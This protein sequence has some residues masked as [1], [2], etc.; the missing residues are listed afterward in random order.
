MGKA[1]CSYFKEQ[2][3]EIIILS[4]GPERTEKNLRF[5]FW[6]GKNPGPWVEE[7]EGAEVLINLAGKN[8]NC[9]Y[10]EKNKK[11]IF[12]SRTNSIEAL[13][14]ALEKCRVRP[15]IWI[16]SASATIYRHAEDRPMTERNLEIGEGFSVEVCKKW[17]KTFWDQTAQF[18]EMRKVILRT[19]LVL[20]KKEGVFPRLKNLTIFGL[21]GKQGNGNQM[22]SWIHESDVA[23]LVEWVLRHPEMNGF[24]NC[25]APFPI[26][27]RELMRS[28]RKCLGVPFGLPAPAWLLELGAILIGTETELI[29]KSRWVLPEKLLNSGYRFKFPDIESAIDNIVNS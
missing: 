14:R 22:V 27:N 19:S 2:A 8:V 13:A 29:L 4:R 18:P 17:E 1:I 9:R 20:G 7:I 3:D 24:I 12:D 28:I 5:I 11:E 25:S 15:E 16:Q 23:G 6:D 26:K 21:G 10:N